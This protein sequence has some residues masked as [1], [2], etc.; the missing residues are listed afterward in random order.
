MSVEPASSAGSQVTWWG[1][2]TTL[3]E[4]AGDRFLTDPLLRDHVGPLRWTGDRPPDQL[5]RSATAVLVSHQHRDH[6][7]LPSLA[8]LPSGTPILVPEGAGQLVGRHVRGDVQELAAGDEV[9][10]G[11]TLVR[12]VVAEHDGRR[13]R[14]GPARPALG[15]VLRAADGQGGA[16]VVY[17]AGDT[18]LHPALSDLAADRIGLALLPVGGWG[19]TLGAGHLDPAGAARALTLVRPA[20]AVPIHWGSLRVP[21]AWRTRPALFT[22]PGRRFAAEAARVAPAVDVV[23]AQIGEPVRVPP[24]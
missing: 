13:G 4:L 11:G 14:T 16:S 10:V 23:V 7:D 5:A 9:T 12:A 3:I 18:D 22:E 17:F 24:T 8:M 2:A 19:P 6:L 15:F 1:H 20:S 21:G